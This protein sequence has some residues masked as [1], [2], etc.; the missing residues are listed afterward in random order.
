MSYPDNGL[1]LK[2]QLEWSN[3]IWLHF[4]GYSKLCGDLHVPLWGPGLVG[5]YAVPKGVMKVNVVAWCLM[6]NYWWVF[7]E[8][9][10]ALLQRCLIKSPMYSTWQSIH[11][12]KWIFLLLFCHSD[13]SNSFAT[14]RTVARQSP[15][16][17]G[18]PSQEYS[19]GLPLPSLDLPDPGIEPASLASPAMADRVSHQLSHQG[20]PKLAEPYIKS[21]FSTKIKQHKHLETVEGKGLWLPALTHSH[22]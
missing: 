9:Q 12:A 6:E 18:F 20:S 5:K 3:S 4:G 22:M 10:S 14:P 17:T 19:S 8:P 21:P 11:I 16:S 13:V 15:L 7:L 1:I 2:K